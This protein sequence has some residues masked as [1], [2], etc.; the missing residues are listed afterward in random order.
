MKNRNLTLL[1]CLAAFL[2]SGVAFAAP[3]FNTVAAGHGVAFSTDFVYGDAYVTVSGPEGVVDRL[4]IEDGAS[5]S[6]AFDQLLVDGQYS[7]EVLLVEPLS[8][9][10]RRGMEALRRGEKTSRAPKVASHTFAGTFRIDGGSV[11]APRLLSQGD[12]D[13]ATKDIVQADDVIITFSLCVG[14]DCVNGETFGSDTIRLKENNLRVHFDDTSNS[15]SFPQN[16]WRILINDTDNGGSNHFSIEDSTAGVVPFRVE[17]GAP[18]NSLVV[19]ADGD[20]GVGTLDPVVELHVVD[21]DRPTLRLEQ[22]GASGFT[23][24]TY[25]LVSNEAN[26]FIRDVTNGSQLPF[27][28]KPGADTDALFI[29]ADNAIGLGTDSPQAPLHVR[30]GGASIVPSNSAVVGFF[31]NTANVGDGAIMGLA[32]GNTGNAQFWYGDTD[33]DNVGRIIYRHGQDVMSLWT[34]GT[35]QVRIDASGDLCIGCDDATVGADFVVGDLG[36]ASYSFINAGDGAWSS[37]S[38]RTLKKNLE[39]ADGGEILE[40]IADVEVYHYDFIEGQTDKLGLMAEDF[41]TIFGRGSDRMINNH[42]V[43]MALWLAVREL[44]AQNKALAQRLE[45]VAAQK[46]E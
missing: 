20:V 6:V 4:K 28:I 32:S 13:L 22:N 33:D 5:L 23:P 17:A 43:Q 14:N 36:G 27:R 2:A 12:Q 35:E 1:V 11:V 7:W 42:E 19:E 41:H 18:V 38:S 46:V 30:A 8:D 39:V 44:T 37:S 26:F 40:K 25:D 45:E 31:Q 29:A 34:N 9:D 21:G 3:S 16:D 24:Q 10:F 15:A